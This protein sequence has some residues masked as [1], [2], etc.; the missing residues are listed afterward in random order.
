MTEL[1]LQ[2]E[3]QLRQSRLLDSQ[4]NQKPNSHADF[5]TKFADFLAFASSSDLTQNGQDFQQE[6]NRYTEEYNDTHYDDTKHEEFAVD[7]NQPHENAP[8][9]ADNYRDNDS[10][11][12]SDDDESYHSNRQENAKENTNENTNENISD[13][14]DNHAETQNSNDNSNDNSK[15]AESDV[16]KNSEN[17]QPVNTTANTAQNNSAP[18]NNELEQLTQLVSN[19]QKVT[20][21]IVNNPQGNAEHKTNDTASP[22]STA[23]KPQTEAL[24]QKAIV[25]DGTQASV[26]LP[27]AENNATG[28]ANQNN[29]ASP[30]TI[31]ANQQ[32]NPNSQAAAT[33]AQAA[34]NSVANNQP[35][36]ANNAPNTISGDISANIATKSALAQ[37]ANK[38]AT[39][40]KIGA[41]NTNLTEQ[42]IE[43]P[44]ISAQ[45]K[46]PTQEKTLLDELPVIAKSPLQSVIAD[47]QTAKA[48]TAQA[49]N[50]AGTAGTKQPQ[51]AQQSAPI[52][53]SQS[54][55]PQ[56]Q[57]QTINS[58]GNAQ[59]QH[60]NSQ[61]V[62]QAEQKPL[63]Q[64]SLNLP[65]EKIT[66]TQINGQE[67]ANAPTKNIQQPLRVNG[68]HLLQAQ[69]NSG[70]QLLQDLKARDAQGQTTP[71]GGAEK[72]AFDARTLKQAQQHQQNATQSQ[73]IVA[74]N[75]QSQTGDKPQT[76]I[77]NN[78]T[79]HTANN[80]LAQQSGQ[81]QSFTSGDG[82]PQ[83][84]P[85]SQNQ[86]Q[87]QS[88][89]QNNQSNSPTQVDN[90]N[91][92][93]RF[94]QNS[95]ESA[96]QIRKL[97]QQLSVKIQQAHR[98]EQTRIN[99]QLRPAELGRVDVQIETLGNGK[100]QLV[101]APEK[102][103]TLQLLQRDASVLQQSLQDAGLNV[104]HKDL[105][106][107]LRQD[108]A[109]GQK[110]KQSG[111]QNSRHATHGDEDAET[112]L[113][114]QSLDE[115]VTVN[116]DGRINARV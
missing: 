23:I 84:Q 108:F 5:D 40:A 46:Q 74:A 116:D 20:V 97:H 100:L 9:H 93:A 95:S 4:P 75:Q 70:S 63:D 17:N 64:K 94:N 26:K 78:T 43:T 36:T 65:V 104:D 49:T 72:S 44:I 79:T 34:Q 25:A 76:Q 51:T 7:Y 77:A 10:E 88:A 30:T 50:I 106:F 101:I 91:N 21:N 54:A 113:P 42:K 55:T 12:R 107:L 68:G 60:A 71:Q 53:A 45:A 80:G 114:E 37:S 83:N 90:S 6:Q 92:A 3:T 48:E 81:Q 1:S 89:A 61:Q 33:T 85:Q 14:T 15:N 29:Q 111:G 57:T 73:P 58:S 82:N 98:N 96:Q 24:Q 99:I 103:D 38:Q 69:E 66:T 35:Q 13:D 16:A 47:T 2:H 105:N 11:Q 86:S 115:Y 56:Q 112:P 109:E 27:Q 62:N 39:D 59:Q 110:G 102:A 19:Q 41:D 32:I 67:G 52:V 18:I 87:A 31:L 28:Q 8:Y 22:Q